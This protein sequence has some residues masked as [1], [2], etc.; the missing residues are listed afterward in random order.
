MYIRISTNGI[1]K[2][3]SSNL[4][5]IFRKNRS[6]VIGKSFTNFFKQNNDNLSIGS[7]F[8]KIKTSYGQG[9]KIYEYLIDGIPIWI[10]WHFTF[11]DNND[12]IVIGDNVTIAAKSGVFHSL[13]DGQS[14]MG[15]PAINKYKFLKK[16]KK[17]Y[18]K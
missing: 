2:E 5:S 18:G 7:R 14:V 11:S 8:L 3:F 13:S 6:Q 15:N 4:L 10:K 17:F 9:E 12:L 16:Y 1:I